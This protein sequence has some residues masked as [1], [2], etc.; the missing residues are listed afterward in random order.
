QRQPRNPLRPGA[1]VPVE[2]RAL[3]IGYTTEKTFRHFASYALDAAAQVDVLDLSLVKDCRSIAIS[4]SSDDLVVD[5]DGAS[6]PFS[7]YGAFYNRSYWADLGSPPRNQVIDRL[8]RAI[9]AWLVMCP[10]TV[11]NRAGAGMSNANKFAH[12]MILKA[13]GFLTPSTLVTSIGE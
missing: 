10:A 7:R 6:F 8:T 4:E 5:L 12:G 1:I 3:L 9:A 11:V 13:M 2:N